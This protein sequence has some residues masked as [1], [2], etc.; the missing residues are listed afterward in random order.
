MASNLKLWAAVSMTAC[1]LVGNPLRADV[2]YDFDQP[3]LFSYGSWDKK[4]RVEQGVA[5]VAGEGVTNAGGAGLNVELDLSAHAEGALTATVSVGPGNQAKLVRLLLVD[6]A[7]VQA[8]YGFPLK[9][10]GESF[11]AVTSENA[12]PLQHPDG[13]PGEKTLNLAQIRQVQ[14]QGDWSGNVPMN[15][16]IDKIE[17]AP[18]TAEQA[19][20]RKTFL[21]RLQR[22]KDERAKARAA[23][24]AK[25]A[26]TPASPAVES[27]Y[28]G[29]PDLIGIHIPGQKLITT[30]PVAYEK[31]DGDT[32]EN[33]QHVALLVQNG[34]LVDSPEV[35]K[36]FRTV[37]GQRRC[38]GVLLNGRNGPPMLKPVET[39]EGDPLETVA[40]DE[41]AS[42]LITSPDDPAYAQ[43][44]APQ[45]VYRKSAPTNNTSPTDQM[46]VQHTIYLKL[47]S[48]MQPGKSYEV[49]FVQLNTREPTSKFVYDSKLTRS[50]AVH[51][52]HTG[53]HPQDP[54][55]RAFLSL[56]LD[57]GGAKSFDD[58]KSFELVDAQGQVVFTAPIQRVM[59]AADTE[60]L[61]HRKNHAGTSVYALDFSAFTSPGQYRVHVPGVGLSDSFK[62]DAGIWRDTFSLGMTG[63]LHQRS[64]IALGP[65]LTD[66]VRPRNLHPDDGFQVY[67]AG[68]TIYQ[69]A[70]KGDGNWFTPLTKSRT[71]EI[72]PDAWG[73]YAD[74][75]DFDRI[76]FHMEISYMHLE[77]AEMFSDLAKMPLR[78]P[79]DERGDALPDLV[80]E[81]MWNIDCFRRLQ[82]KDGG[83][84]GG[85]EASAHPRTYETSW[86]ESLVHMAYAS[87]PVS[88]Y[89][90][91]ACAAKLSRALSKAGD[92]QRAELFATTARRAYDYAITRESSI[93]TLTNEKQKAASN[94]KGWKRLAALELYRLTREASFHDTFKA[95]FNPNSTEGEEL[96]LAQHAAFAYATL[97][98]DLSPDASLVAGSRA[99]LIN[100]ADIAVKFGDGNVFG[101]TTDIPSLPVIGFVGY[102]STPG[103]ITQSV[104]RAHFLTGDAKYLAATVRAC[105]YA[106]GANPGNR[107]YTTGVG[108]DWPRAPLHYDSRGSAQ[109]APSG[110][111]ITGQSDPAESW[112]FNDWA[113]TWKL[114]TTMVPNSRSWPA[115]EAYVDLAVWPSMNE[116]MLNQTMG[117]NIYWWG[118]LAGAARPESA[119]AGKK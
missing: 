97:P 1:L 21:D 78:V 39:L 2:L 87:D 51:A 10:V 82:D 77:L 17:V 23:A 92:A 117:R 5:I 15:V 12:V 55:K 112:G 45:A 98:V 29:G 46:P 116:L 107:T 42:Y 14:I 40:I 13:L 71:E 6:S 93:D 33:G 59:A 91:A 36:V 65:P 48:P 66:Y 16:R 79:A 53:Y 102:Y 73:G 88:S 100:F 28:P 95:G 106:L 70:D 101:I 62:I 84:G 104:P 50:Q 96:V 61:L 25:I 81:A 103:M 114:G 67:R 49:K 86:N 37:D 20:V 83:V 115:S 3:M 90:Y 58:V 110:L 7:G 41:A 113:H 68:L 89:T 38:I 60:Q 8:L 119:A 118:Y 108:H 4:V 27:I 69:A 54:Y 76:A 32:Y 80:N 74:A 56:W 24:I 85:I 35:V 111:V 72:V 11:T 18:P 43:P 64:G 47:P 19:A 26:H 30:V 109:D 63:F 57:T 31:Q 94:L 105:N 34:Q 99:M 52:I 9:D 75:G 22:E 44:V